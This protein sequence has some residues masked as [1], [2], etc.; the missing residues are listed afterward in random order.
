MEVRVLVVDDS[1]FYRHRVVKALNAEKDLVVVG[2]ASNGLEAVELAKQLLPDVI[3]MDVSMPVMDGVSAVRRIMA[4][5]PTP[6]LM[7]SSLTTKGAQATFDAMDA[8]AADFL[9]KQG[10]ELNGNPQE[11]LRHLCRRVR[12]LA[13]SARIRAGHPSGEVRREIRL[14]TRSQG[15]AAVTERVTIPHGHPHVR[16]VRMIVIGTS[17][18]GPV[19]VQKLLLALPADFPI[20]MLIVQHMPPAF[21]RTFAERLNKLSACRVKEA[22]DG[23]RPQPA[24]VYV[25][26]GG[27]QTTLKGHGETLHFQVRD[28]APEDVYRPCIDI[29]FSSAAATLPGGILGVVLTGMGADGKDGARVLKAKG[30]S[31]WVQDEESSVIFGMPKAVL[32]AGFADQVMSLEEIGNALAGLA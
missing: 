7:F 29:A 24:S 31:V 25:A 10:E 8:G 3:T 16:D 21:T 18:G 30:S 26:P 14:E 27:C 9:T 6:I 2:E 23:E 5:R 17:T 20:P 22:E 12:M 4:D 28:G 1:V 11:T 32:D 13:R 19:A 15:N